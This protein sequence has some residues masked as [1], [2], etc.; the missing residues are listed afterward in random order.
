MTVDASVVPGLLFLLAELVALAAIG[1][2][3]VRTALRES[4][5]RVA[6]A[7]G[8]VVGPAIWGVVV[9][10][11]MYVLPGLAGATVGWIFV[12]A[13]A[14]VLIWRAPKP[15]RPRL[16]TAAGFALAAVALF[17]LALA[18]RQM[19]GIPDSWIHMGLAA[20]LRA[21]EFPPEASWIPGAPVPYHHGTDLLNGLLAPPSGPD[22][23]FVEELL[24]AY[25]WVSLALVVVTALLRRASGFAV[26]IGAPLLLTL[27]I[28]TY[29]PT[30]GRILEAAVP[31]GIPADGIRASLTDIYWPLLELPG[32]PV[33]PNIFKPPFTLSYALAFIVLARAA[34]AGR[35]SWLSV[36]TLAALIGFL[37][38]TSSTLTPIV[39][40]LWAGLEAIH[41]I[42]SRR[43]GS[44]WQ[45]DLIRSASGLALATTLLLAGRFASL[46]PADSVSSGLS[47][48]W[49]GYLDHRR[50]LGTFDRLPGGIGI[51]GLGPLAVA[52][53]AVLLAWRDRLVRALAV[54]AGLLALAS[55]TLNYEPNS[56]DVVRLGG[57]ARNFALFALLLA[58]G[59]R[60][61]G[62]RPA[63]L[64]YA[65][66]ALLVGVI[67]WPTIVSPVRNLGPAI[68]TGVELANAQRTRDTPGT[69]FAIEA[70][71]S[72]GIVDYIRNNTAVDARMFSPDPHQMTFNTGRPNASGFAGLVH[73]IPSQGP[74]HRDVLR[75]LEPATIRRLG[76][77]YIH[78]PDSWVEGLPDEAV[79]RL[80]DPT[81]FEL[82]VRDTS[83]SLYRVL[84]A[85]LKLDAPPARG[86]YEALRQAIPASTT[87][88]LLA[89]AEF[90]MR[91]L[92]RT[93]WTLSHVRLL[94]DITDRGVMHLL[95]PV[96]TEPLGDNVPYLVIA[97]ASFVPWMF[98]LTSRQPIWWNEETAVYALDGAVKPIM[99]PPRAQPLPFEVQLSNVHAADGRIAF[100][101]T[102]NDRAAGRWTSQDWIMIAT[103]AP[104]WD[105]PTQ[106]LHDGTPA[107]AMWF[108]SHLNPGK[109]T[110]SLAYEFDFLAPSLA[111]RR[112][113]G[114]LKP[115]DR[116]EAVF[117]S[118]SYVLAVRL[119]H[120]YQPGFWRDAAIIP[121]LKITV[122]ETGEVL[123]R[124]HQDAG[125]ESAR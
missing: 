35:R 113:H 17:W 86:S 57:H 10:L 75:H 74:E 48:G 12:L 55:L 8:L 84:P 67:V 13:L 18:S 16:R 1:Y 66:G 125:G 105:L 7:Q 4:D 42:Q 102:F 3:I 40:V 20:S 5:D 61:V 109:G 11:V 21:G 24:G 60:L 59:I 118:D 68:D 47:L 98:P 70:I 92:M 2:V 108:V 115:L 112:E 32:N 82:L 6:L 103:E 58:L 116:S 62:L 26:L 88:Y 77:G 56:A 97:P 65:A 36:T 33:L 111:V 31:T 9:N 95:T 91:P 54:G 83:E 27:G 89:P 51:L 117:G 23:A 73:L 19:V 121:V 43:A 107:I 39:F 101:A 81:L 119:R 110:S 64:R 41:L 124:V 100:T 50:L 78:A 71:P 34:H 114:A 99:S 29:S 90:D 14:A 123:Y 25:A 15:V 85:F 104:P 38:L 44:A 52:G 28:R 46:I 69:R 80:Y 79:E 120:E 30:Q 94:G 93:A 53:T 96:Q 106:L 45:S 76:I 87:V 72:D 37:G 63:R 49:N 122:S 22:L